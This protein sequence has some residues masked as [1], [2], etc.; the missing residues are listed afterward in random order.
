MLS[1]L[2]RNFGERISVA[3]RNKNHVLLAGDWNLNLEKFESSDW[4]LS[5][6]AEALKDICAREDLCRLDVGP[7]FTYCKNDEV[8]E[9]TLDF[10]LSSNSLLSTEKI[11]C[12]F[13][14][15]DAICVNIPTYAREQREE[16]FIRQRSKIKNIPKYKRDMTKAM[17]EW[18]QEFGG[19]SVEEMANN[20]TSKLQSVMSKHAPV[21]RIRLKKNFQ[22]GLTK[23][24]KKLMRDRD[25]AKKELYTCSSN[26][27]KVRH[28][29]YK[30]IRNKV[31]SEIRRGRRSNADKKLKSGENP[32]HVVRDLLGD[33]KSTTLPLMENGKEIENN[34][35]KADAMNS[36][37]VSKVVNLQSKIDQSRKEDPIKRISKHVNRHWRPEFS[38]REVTS[39][40]VTKILRKMK[41][42]KACGLDQ[43]SS[44][45]IKPVIEAIAPA[46]TVLINS[47]LAEGIFP[48]IFK[49]AKVVC[50]YKGRGSKKEKSSYRPVSNL[51]LIGK[52]IEIAV[53]MQLSEYCEKYNVLGIHQHGFRKARSSSTALL[54]AVTRWRAERRNN[55]VQGVL[56]MDL[57]AAYD[58]LSPE[59]FIRKAE[60]L[61]FDKNVLNWFRSY[62]SGRS[63]VVEVGSA[64]SERLWTRVGTPQ[65]S[66]LSCLIFAIYVGDFTMWVDKY[67]DSLPLAYADDT[68]VTLWAE[69]EADLI[70]K[71]QE[72]GNDILTFSHQTNSLQTQKK[73]AY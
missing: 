3:R 18:I 71:L 28:E 25:T 29:A 65:G 55:K 60:A 48:E 40:E 4:Y 24:T 38:F 62:L 6:V 23:S 50:I 14:D 34:Q 68:F 15:H 2:L 1:Q 49:I 30:R 41:N 72:V 44:V 46:F 20:L 5:N 26:E 16:I 73:Q 12:G 35:D 36:F 37:F 9:S 10:F 21:R 67:K 70:V 31:K 69:T 39:N 59:I 33:R 17:G 61:K 11:T 8:R 27:R 58:V 47:S 43:I 66:P 52:C 54:T 13:S 22:M 56:L 19:K 7:T 42:S 64:V 53:E 45:L 57:S 63:Q 32:W 51:S